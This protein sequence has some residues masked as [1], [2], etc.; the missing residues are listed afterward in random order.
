[1]AHQR[2]VLRYL[3]TAVVHQALLARYDCQGVSRQEDH[4]DWTGVFIQ[5]S[6]LREARSA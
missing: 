5:A 4:D 2:R 1:M 3:C 6:T